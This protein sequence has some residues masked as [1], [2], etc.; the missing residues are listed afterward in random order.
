MKTHQNGIAL[1]EVMLATLL[2][3][4]GLLGTIGMQARAYSAMSGAG[5]R[6]EATMA[7]EKL[8]GTMSNDLG[9]LSLY[10]LPA[11]DPAPAAP[12]VPDQR[13]AAWYAET[14]KAI[15]GAIIVVTV[16]PT[17]GTTR[18]QVVVSISWVRRANDPTY[19]NT[20]T[21]YFAPA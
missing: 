9:N 3:A 1:L 2:L 16:T 14:R 19:T 18:T 20:V 21:S 10:K 11:A 13:M 5:A 15:P 17:P 4:V 12:P 7:T 8:L 6:A